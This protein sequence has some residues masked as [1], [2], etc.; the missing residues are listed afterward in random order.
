[1]G[2]EMERIWEERWKKNYDWNILY[3]TLLSTIEI[4]NK[5]D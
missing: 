3:E 2:G 4:K 5:R 1:M